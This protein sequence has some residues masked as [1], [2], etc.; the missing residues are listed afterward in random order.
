MKSNS[1]ASCPLWVVRR[2][3]FKD[4]WGDSWTL[5]A[6]AGATQEDDTHLPKEEAGEG[7]LPARPIALFLLP[8]FPLLPLWP[9]LYSSQGTRNSSCHLKSLPYTN[10]MPYIKNKN[11]GGGDLRAG[12]ILEKT[13]EETRIQ[14]KKEKTVYSSQQG[15]G[16]GVCVLSLH[17]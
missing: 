8:T 6:W 14:S 3:W 17:L 2:T 12:F 4:C 10:P 5:L 13:P 11:L 15:L 7:Y 9:L 1:E 16:G